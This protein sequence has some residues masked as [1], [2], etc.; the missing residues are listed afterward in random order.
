VFLEVTTRSEKSVSNLFYYAQRV[1]L[2]PIS[3]LFNEN[4]RELTG[5]FTRALKFIFRKNDLDRDLVLNDFEMLTLNN[6]VFLNEKL[7]LLGLKALKEMIHD[8]C[9]DGVTEQGVTFSGFVHLNR[10]MVNRQK[11]ATCWMMLRHYGFDDSLELKLEIDLD[12]GLAYELSASAETFLLS[13]F[14]QYARGEALKYVEVREICSTLPCPP[15]AY[16]S[17]S[18]SAWL[19]FA[20]RVEVKEQHSMEMTSW[21]ALWHSLV[22]DSPDIVLRSLAYLGYSSP[23]KRAVEVLS[24][25]NLLQK[26]RRKM[27]VVYVVGAS[28]VGKSCLLNSFIR[29]SFSTAHKPISEAWQAAGYEDGRVLVMK[30]FPESETKQLWQSLDRCDLVLMLTDNS[31]RADRYLQGLMLPET[32]PRMLVQTKCDDISR[33]PPQFV[34]TLRRR[35]DQLFTLVLTKAV[36]PWTALTEEGLKLLSNEEDRT[37][38]WKF[39]GVITL[40]LVV[41]AFVWMRYLRPR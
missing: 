14:Q 36:S 34:S 16:G 35:P 27:L 30:E 1:V 9:E 10:L 19:S 15:W 29:K 11:V 7:D 20:K 33:P 26:S 24:P 21:L 32:T 23:L 17:S 4:T 31:D 8:Q 38:S 37:G 40:T 25:K 12:P 5:E 13:L 41:G 3:P 18:D 2:C 6:S 28:A 39:V 22:L